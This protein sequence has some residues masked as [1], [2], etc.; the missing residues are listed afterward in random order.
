MY[1]LR[2]QISLGAPARSKSDARGDRGVEKREIQSSRRQTEPSAKVAD[3][4]TLYMSIYIYVCYCC[5]SR[6]CISLLIT[7]FVHVSIIGNTPVDDLP[8]ERGT[9]SRPM[10]FRHLYQQRRLNYTYLSLFERLLETFLKMRSLHAA[11]LY[12]T[13]AANSSFTFVLSNS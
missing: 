6:N 7:R 12:F 10:K 4:T 5:R 13:A 8:N 3:E 1:H 9:S 2:K 11:V